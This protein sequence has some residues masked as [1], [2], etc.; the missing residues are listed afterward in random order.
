MATARLPRITVKPWRAD[1]PVLGTDT[2]SAMHAGVFWGYVG[3][4]EGLLG[5]LRQ[6]HGAALPA[7]ATGGLARLFAEHIDGSL[8]VD[9]DLTLKGLVRIYVLNKS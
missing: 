8:I 9:A 4:V 7:I 3:M 2:V 6:A 1:M 5:R